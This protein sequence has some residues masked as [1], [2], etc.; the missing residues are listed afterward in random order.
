MP[1]NKISNLLLVVVVKL[2]QFIHT[3]KLLTRHYHHMNY[4]IV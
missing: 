2:S 3:Y 1:Y 4:M